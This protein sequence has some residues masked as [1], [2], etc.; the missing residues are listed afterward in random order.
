MGIRPTATGV[1]AE[2]IQHYNAE[3]PVQI[4][5]EH[6]WIITGMWRVNPLR[7]AG[8]QVHLDMENLLNLD[9]PGCLWCEEHW[10]PGMESVPCKGGPTR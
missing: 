4:K 10:R 3:F 6:L 1:K 5:G 7:V 9:G 2:A 8:Q